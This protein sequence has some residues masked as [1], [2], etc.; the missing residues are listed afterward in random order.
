MLWGGEAEHHR[1][2]EPPMERP[3]PQRNDLSRSLLALDQNSTIIAVIEMSQSNWLV[4][5]VIP[6]VD[7]SVRARASQYN[8]CSRTGGNVPSRGF[9]DGQHRHGAAEE[10]EPAAIGGNVLVVA[11][12]RAE[13]VAQ[14]I[15][16]ATEPS[17]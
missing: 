9:Q 8:L 13:E 10:L 2:R 3:M 16:S 7:G 6:D 15:V 1:R 17:R 4:A 5:G 12:V 14:F 11:G